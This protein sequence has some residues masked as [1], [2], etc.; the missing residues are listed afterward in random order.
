MRAKYTDFETRVTE[1]DV[2]YRSIENEYRRLEKE[3]ASCRAMI[4][5]I[6]VRREGGDARLGDIDRRI[7]ELAPVIRA[8]EDDLTRLR[9]ERLRNTGREHELTSEISGVKSDLAERLKEMEAVDTDLRKAGE[10]LASLRA[11]RDFSPRLSDLLPGTR[12]E[13]EPRSAP[14]S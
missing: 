10:N 7:A 4:V 9:E 13:C 8:A 6:R 3:I 5:T 11:E 2:T 12:K 1:R 14:R